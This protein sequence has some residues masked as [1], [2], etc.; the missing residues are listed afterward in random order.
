MEAPPAPPPA[1]PRARAVASRGR[2][3]PDMSSAR[4]GRAVDASSA[5]SRGRAS[6]AGSR[7]CRGRRSHGGRGCR[8]PCRGKRARSKLP[9]DASTAR[10]R[11]VRTPCRGRRAKERLPAPPR[12]APPRRE[13]RGCLRDPVL[14]SARGRCAVLG[15]PG[16]EVRLPQ[17]R[18]SPPA[19]PTLPQTSSGSAARERRRRRAPRCGRPARHVG[20][21]C[22]GV[23]GAACACVWV[24]LVCAAV[25]RAAELLLLGLARL[26]A[27]QAELHGAALCARDRRG[28]DKGGRRDHAQRGRAAPHLLLLGGGHRDHRGKHAALGYR[29]FEIDG[30]A[31]LSARPRPLAPRGELGRGRRRGRGRLGAE[32]EIMGAER[33]WALAPPV[34]GARHAAV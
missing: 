23:V 21:A 8:S 32:D 9:R 4:H 2:A 28:G 16:R 1:P 25:G 22:R 10:P 27:S 30:A 26:R 24:G 6:A 5:A 15:V 3:Y 14:A 31:A 20:D 17:T 7:R 12:R 33:L 11:H 18:G 19:P 29:G 13:T 34:G